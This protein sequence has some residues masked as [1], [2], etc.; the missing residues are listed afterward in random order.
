[1]SNSSPPV[2]AVRPSKS[3]R[4]DR[5]IGALKLSP[6]V[7]I[8]ELAEA[9]GVSTETVRR[10]IDDLSSRGL[11]ARTYGGATAPMGR[12]PGVRERAA[13]MVKERERIAGAACRMINPGDVVMVD[14][15]A[16]TLHLARCMAGARVDATV[17]T[18]GI[19]V[20]QTLGAAETIRVILCPGAYSA[21]EDGVYGQDTCEFLTRFHANVAFTSSGGLTD[22]GIT[23]VDSQA[24]FVKRAMFARAERRVF[25]VDHA[26]FG[27]RLLEVVMPLSILTNIVTDTAP[28]A[29]LA[30]AIAKAD[31]E[32]MVA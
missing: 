19:R 4:H 11:V 7:R 5:I 28:P 1:M 31:I 13:A 30:Q 8:S 9:F 25:M 27:V 17:I 18:N 15:G 29:P 23:D 26:K 21:R 20:A 2:A 12:E 32:L 16:T 24:A 10:D 6:T 3:E 14:S 22:G